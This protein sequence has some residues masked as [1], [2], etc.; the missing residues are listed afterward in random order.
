M[1]PQNRIIE[2]QT[3]IWKYSDF[4]EQTH[5]IKEQTDKIEE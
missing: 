1:Y 3:Q 5:K 2:E 4:E